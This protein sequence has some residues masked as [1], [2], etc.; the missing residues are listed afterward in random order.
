MPPKTKKKRKEHRETMASQPSQQGA[1]PPPVDPLK[2][3]AELCVEKLDVDPSEFS[4]KAEQKT[5]KNKLHEI[6]QELGPELFKTLFNSDVNVLEGWRLM[7]IAYHAQNN[8]WKDYAQKWEDLLSAMEE[9]VKQKPK[10]FINHSKDWDRVRRQLRACYRPYAVIA[11][12]DQMVND[13][14]IKLDSSMKVEN[15]KKNWQIL[16]ELQKERSK[17]SRLKEAILAVCESEESDDTEKAKKL[18]QTKVADLQLAEI[19]E[20]E[21]NRNEWQT[22]RLKKLVNRA[23]RRH[24]KVEKVNEGTTKLLEDM[25]TFA[26]EVNGKRPARYGKSETDM[27]LQIVKENKLD[28]EEVIEALRKQAEV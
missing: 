25:T 9:I 4:K 12:I 8:V 1:T 2:G 17:V 15:L 16:I 13:P 23:T 28:S 27:I 3:L 7:S 19:K 10:S 20:L 21:T 6:S 14:E 22:A 5:E 18:I 11:L 26:G 24:E